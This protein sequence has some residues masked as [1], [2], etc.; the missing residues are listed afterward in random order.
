MIRKQEI[1][2]QIK[3]LEVEQVKIDLKRIYGPEI[4]NVVINHVPESQEREY[5]YFLQQRIRCNL[6]KIIKP[7]ENNSNPRIG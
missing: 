6:I 1:I 2:R 5:C 4:C 3:R 7:K